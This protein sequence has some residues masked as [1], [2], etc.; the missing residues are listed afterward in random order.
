M[1]SL[2]IM[3]APQRD[4]HCAS[5]PAGSAGLDSSAADPGTALAQAVGEAWESAVA[6]AQATAPVVRGSGSS[7]LY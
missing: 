1:L 2:R 7:V 6:P 3:T 4:A 5:F